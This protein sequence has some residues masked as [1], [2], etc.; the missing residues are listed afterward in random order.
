MAKDN[1]LLIVGGGVVAFALLNGASASEGES[2]GSSQMVAGGSGATYGVSDGALA[3]LQNS[4]LPTKTKK[5]VKTIIQTIE[6]S[7]DTRL[8]KIDVVNYGS[9]SV[10]YVDVTTKSGSSTS[11]AKKLALNP[12]TVTFIKDTSGEIQGAYDSVAMMSRT[13]KSAQTLSDNRNNPITNLFS[14]G[15]SSSSSSSPVQTKKQVKVE[16]KEEPSFWEKRVSTVKKNVSFLRG[17]F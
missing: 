3:Q 9:S 11:T 5:E 12:N 8:D 17:L 1:T 16:K 2:S 15:S 14:G 13:K 6:G 7:P 10:N 4:A